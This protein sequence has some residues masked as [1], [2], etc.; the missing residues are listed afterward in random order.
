MILEILDVF[1]F[2]DCLESINVFILLRIWFL[3]WMF[4]IDLFKC[5]VYLVLEYCELWLLLVLKIF[6]VVWLIYWG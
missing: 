5:Y 4:V 2:V 6:N 3:M 1:Y